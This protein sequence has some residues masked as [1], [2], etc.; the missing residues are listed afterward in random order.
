[1][2]TPELCASRHARSP[3]RDLPAR[4]LREVVDL[5]RR[6]EAASRGRRDGG[7][8]WCQGRGY[9]GAGRQRGAAH[10]AAEARQRLRK[11]KGGGRGGGGEAMAE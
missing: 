8:A 2:R 6:L 11:G 10:G 3:V 9:R 5:Q 1:M 7:V 4:V